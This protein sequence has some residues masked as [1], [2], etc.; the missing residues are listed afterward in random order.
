MATCSIED[1]S[2]LRFKHPYGK[3]DIKYRIASID[4]EVVP[5]TKSLYQETVTLSLICCKCSFFLLRH[6]NVIS[7]KAEAL[8]A[9][10]AYVRGSQFRRLRSVGSVTF[11]GC[12]P[13]VI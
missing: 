2:C 11:D 3:D 7:S 4:S 13:L 9:L 5:D 8:A 6:H 12:V 10:T 1:K